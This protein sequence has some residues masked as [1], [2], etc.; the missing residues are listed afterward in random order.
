[1]L[2]DPLALAALN[3]PPDE[4]AA[5][6]VRARAR[7]DVRRRSAAR[8]SCCR[9]PLDADVR[10]ARARLHRGARRHGANRSA[11]ASRLERGRASAAVDAAGES[12]PRRRS[13]A[14]VPWFAL[15]RLFD[16]TA[17]AGGDRSTRARMASSPIVT[18]NLWFDRPRPSR[19]V[20]RASRPADAVG[21]RPARHLRRRASHLSLVSSGAAASS[22]RKRGACCP[23]PRELR[24][25]LPS[26]RAGRLRRA[27]VVRERRATFSLAPGQ[28]ARPDDSH[29]FAGSSLRAIGPIPV[30]RVPLRARPSGTSPQTRP[31][32]E[33]GVDRRPMTRLPIQTTHDFHHRPLPGN[34][35]QGP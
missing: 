3:Q 11:R 4:A 32:S 29:P 21:V 17:A 30:C 33:A 35:A 28:P 15:A 7:G 31:W 19:A 26:S 9:P 10:R 16:G 13:L 34:R 24:D 25:A 12:L 22:V 2:W 8:A 5:P 27:T 23:C 20:C 14:A 18:V 6:V 1:M